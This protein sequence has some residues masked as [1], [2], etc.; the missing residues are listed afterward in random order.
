MSF[1][2]RLPARVGVAH[3]LVPAASVSVPERALDRVEDLPVIVGAL[4]VTRTA[5]S[6]PQFA[7]NV[8]PGRE[9][10]LGEMWMWIAGHHADQHSAVLGA[11]NA[12]V[13][14]TDRGAGCSAA[15]GIDR[16]SAQRHFQAFT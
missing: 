13:L 4:C 6:Q 2:L 8:Q 3:A 12:S 1:R 5:R 9:R 11:V 15:S 16:A 10:V 14:R 7:R